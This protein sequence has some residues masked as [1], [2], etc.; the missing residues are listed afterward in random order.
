[1]VL[2]Q[3]VTHLGQQWIM[4]DCRQIINIHLVREALSPS[5]TNTDERFAGIPCPLRHG[6]LG[7]HLIAGINDGID[8]RW[9]Q[10]WPVRAV[11]EILNANHGAGRM[12]LRDT[13]AHRLYLGLSDRPRQCMNLPV[14]V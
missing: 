4:G 8:S 6:C 7:A 10:T 14:D 5:G 2:T 1:M 12:N 9:Q 3:L 11:N 13:V